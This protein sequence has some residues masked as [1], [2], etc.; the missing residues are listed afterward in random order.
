LRYCPRATLW[1]D[2]E[3]KGGAEMSPT[4]LTGE[5][6]SLTLRDLT[7]PLVRRKRVWMLTFLCVFAV[8]ALIGLLRR[9]TYESHMSILISREG[10]RP[11][12]ATEAKAQTGAPTPSLTDQEVTS[13]A[14]SL[15][16]QEFLER[17]VLTNGLQNGQD[18]QFFSF[19]L[20]RQTETVRVAH[21]VRELGRQI[22][23][24][25]RSSAQL[26]EVAYRSKDPA[27]AYGVLNSLGNLYLA[28]H[29]LRPATSNPQSQGYE[30]AV[31]DAESG[32]REF[33]RTQGRSDTGRDFAR[34]QA[35][36][37][38]QSHIIEHAIADDEQKIRA[39]QEQ[40][41]VNPQ[42]PAPHQDN[43]STNLLLQSLGARLQAAETKRAQFLQKYAP[44][45]ALVQDANKEVSEAKAAIAAAQK[46][47]QGKQTPARQ[48][49]LAFMRGRLVQDQADLATQRSSLNAIRHVLEEM[50]AQVIKRG[51]NS[52]DDADLER[53]VKA[54]EQSYLRYL[55]RREQER[56]AGAR[57]RPPTLS[58]ALATP[59]SVPR[60]PVHGRGVIFLVA[61]GLATAV[62]FPAALILDCV[63]PCFHNPTQVIETLGIAVVLAVP[64]MTA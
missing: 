64:K 33:Q 45:Y 53:E 57:D 2:H 54:D 63:D 7:V 58:A 29:A 40:M 23:I 36:A 13:E 1:S 26:I 52:L 47:S 61:L 42:Q 9:Q 43:D 32:L 27:R 17:V 30:T 56:T 55:S 59:P 48:P 8:A 24:H 51:G 6:V 11:A 12:E 3:R 22:Q 14:E 18:S 4:L 62:S 50:K 41:R 10:L 31:E 25:T 15:K 44:N 35:A 20:P 19:L 49:T 16:R 5:D 60:S 21:A 46:S 38:G 39:D 34:Q 37:A 28:Q